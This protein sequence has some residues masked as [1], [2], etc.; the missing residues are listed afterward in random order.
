MTGAVDPDSGHDFQ[1]PN[2]RHNE[3]SNRWANGLVSRSDP[4]SDIEGSS[5]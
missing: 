4:P 2:D 5:Q 3:L 1:K